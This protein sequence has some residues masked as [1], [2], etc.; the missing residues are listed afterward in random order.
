M[1]VTSIIMSMAAEAALL[2]ESREL[3]REMSTLLRRIA[4]LWEFLLNTK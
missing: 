2:R 4:S 1:G 3:I